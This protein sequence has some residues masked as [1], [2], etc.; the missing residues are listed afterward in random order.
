MRKG[1]VPVFGD[2]FASNELAANDRAGNN[3]VLWTLYHENR[4]RPVLFQMRGIQPSLLI[5]DPKFMEDFIDLPIEKFDRI[6]EYPFEGKMD[7]FVNLITKDENFNGRKAPMM[8]AL[9]MAR[10][11]IHVP[12]VIEVCLTHLKKLK[13]GDRVLVDKFAVDLPYDIA[14]TLIFG[15][16]LNKVGKVDYINPVTNEQSKI[17]FYDS[18]SAFV[19]DL[20][21]VEGDPWHLAFPIIQKLKLQKMTKAIAT[22]NVNM[23]I[24]LKDY[25]SRS[26][27]T[28]S[29]YHT[30]LNEKKYSADVVLS[31]AIAVLA[32]GWDLSHMVMR[33]IYE[34]SHLPDARHQIKQEVNKFVL[35]DGKYS[36]NQLS[37]WLSHEILDKMTYVNNFVKE[38]L[39]VESGDN[40]FTRMAHQTITHSS[41]LVIP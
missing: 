11:F 16:A 6:P 39:R 1:Y 22:N 9:G 8:K 23:G 28:K 36:L 17:E 21:V 27:V 12:T 40:S 10:S 32:V 35:K 19:N 25:L 2:V 34:I 7:I 24:V 14:A 20:Y 15:E 33:L 31:D 30:L 38:V 4:G 13:R 5:H 26:K 3:S 29:A 41:G 18:V 37:E